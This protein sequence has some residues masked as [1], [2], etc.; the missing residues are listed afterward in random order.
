MLGRILTAAILFL[1]FCAGCALTV[2]GGWIFYRG[3][4]L[5]EWDPV[6]MGTG[7]GLSAG[8][9]GVL[10]LIQMARA[11]AVTA[12]HSARIVELL[13]AGTTTPRD[14]SGPKAGPRLTA[15]RRPPR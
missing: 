2:G 3:L 4:W 5:Y 7:G 14:T 12:R 11:Q 15:E 6:L 10:A 1:V 8:G 13:E 9:L